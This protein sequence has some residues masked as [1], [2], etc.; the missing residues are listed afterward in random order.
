VRTFWE[1]VLEGRRGEIEPGVLHGYDQAFMDRLKVLIGKTSD[2]GLRAKLVRMLDCPVRDSKGNCRSFAEYIHAA[3]L[4][5]RIA[6]QYDIEAALSYVVGKM[7]MDR[8]EATGALKANLFAGFTER[9]KGKGPRWIAR[10]PLG[11][12]FLSIVATSG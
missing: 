5:N 7:L 8:S 3:L 11:R 6:D 12:I 9:P 2:P 1:W 4:K 10:T